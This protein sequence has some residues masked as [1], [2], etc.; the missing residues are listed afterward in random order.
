MSAAGQLSILQHRGWSPRQQIN[1]AHTWTQTLPRVRCSSCTRLPTTT[2]SPNKTRIK[3]KGST[4]PCVPCGS[5]KPQAPPSDPGHSQEMAKRAL[6]RTVSQESRSSSR[7]SLRRAPKPNTC[8]W[9]AATFWLHV[10]MSCA[11]LQRSPAA[12]ASRYRP[13]SRCMPDSWQK[14]RDRRRQKSVK[15][16][17]SQADLLSLRA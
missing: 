7:S 14:S 11:A 13:T 1:R 16:P 9:M 8:S 3:D 15:A 10:P 17:S 5:S 2:Q 12:P 6:T 4:Q